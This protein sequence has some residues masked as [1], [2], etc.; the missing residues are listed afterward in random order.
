MN[1]RP[2]EKLDVY[3]IAR[4]LAPRVHR[5]SFRLP[6]FELYEEG[7]QARRSSKSVSNQT[8]EGHA[9]RRY[10]AQYVQYLAR[11]YGSAEETIEHLTYVIETG[12]ACA[13]GQDEAASLLAEY[14]I[15]AKKVYNY[16]TSVQHGHDTSFYVREKREG[17]GADTQ[18]SIL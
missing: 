7:C 1:T 14:G 10:K 8:V 16:M 6:K 18:D 3:R 15:L 13:E 2:H 9:P 4:A 5:L 12:S 17:W 11:A